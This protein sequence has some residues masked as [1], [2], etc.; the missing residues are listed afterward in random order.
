MARRGSHL[1]DPG[2]LARMLRSRLPATAFESTRLP[3]QV[4]AT[5]VLA[6]T[7]V[8]LSRGPVLPALLASTAIPA[9]FPPVEIDGRLLS[10]GGFAYQ[11]PFESVVAQGAT[12]LYVLPTGYSCARTQP[13]D[14]ALGH[15]LNALNHLTVSKLIGSIQHYARALDVRIVPPLCPMTVS[16][17]DFRHTAQL[18]ERSEAQTHDWLV[19]DS[20]ARSDVTQRPLLSELIPPQLVPHRH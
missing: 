10:D 17:L 7:A 16:P 18:I 3:C 2:P 5:D 14:S 20:E 9:L 11:A 12:R 6:G 13:P 15:A 1:Y 19:Q 4:V 8:T